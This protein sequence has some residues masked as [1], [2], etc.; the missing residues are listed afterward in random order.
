[1][2]ATVFQASDL[3]NKRTEFIA[4]GREGAAML[5][6]K[7]GFALVMVPN[8]QYEVYRTVS[9]GALAV[10]R[11]ENAVR[12]G[13]VRASELE[14][15]SWLTYLDDDDRAEMFDDLKDALSA[16]LSTRTLEPF[17]RC[18]A[19]WRRTALALSDPIRREILTGPGGADEDYAEVGAPV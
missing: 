16:A 3:S 17:D 14:P 10:F 4:A 8:C 1:M 2:T 19:D 12:R 9:E 7:D 15:L 6:D 5:R 11:A 13:H 18:V